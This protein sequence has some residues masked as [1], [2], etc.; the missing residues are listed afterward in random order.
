MNLSRYPVKSKQ[1][2][3]FSGVIFLCLCLLLTA[4]GIGYLYFSDQPPGSLSNSGYYVRRTKVFYHPGFGLSAP[5]EVVDADHDS[6]VILDGSYAMD[7]FHVFYGGSPIPDADPST[8][9]LLA[10]PFSRDTRHVYASGTI[11][12]DDPK[13][14]E[15]LAEN[16]TRDSQHVY[17]S[18]AVISDD[19]ADLV[20]VGSWDYYTYVKDSKSVFVNGGKIPNADPATFEVIVD[21]YSRDASH[22]FYFN[23]LIPK[24]DPATFEILESPYAK[25]STLVF[26]QENVIPGADPL[27]FRVLNANFECSADAKFAYY[28]DQTI[29]NFDA[30][31]LPVDVQVNNCSATE[32]YITP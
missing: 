32:L 9:E 3:I 31:T 8:F 19:P 14:F 5:F 11:F 27:T 13:N 18:G 22:I 23:V 12:S 6:F 28:Q 1:T 4:A 15:I 26:W 10:S 7:E 2:H 24:A 17:W 30:S 20:L 29:K 16:L 25:D 21:A